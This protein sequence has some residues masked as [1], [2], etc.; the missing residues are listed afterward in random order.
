VAIAGIREK[1]KYADIPKGLEGLGI[2][3]IISGL[4]AL[5]F[6]SFSGISL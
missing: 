6:S 2:T 1:L 5:G 4:M 3:F